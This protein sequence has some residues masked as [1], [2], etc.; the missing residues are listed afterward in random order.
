[1]QAFN[2]HYLQCIMLRFRT[3][4]NNYEYLISIHSMQSYLDLELFKINT[5]A[6]NA[7]ISREQK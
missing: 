4:H 1:M 7:I 5:R 2:D 6:F 3:I